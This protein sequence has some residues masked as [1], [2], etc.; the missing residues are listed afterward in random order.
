MFCSRLR[1]QIEA[2]KK[3][4]KII[5]QIWEQSF[6]FGS[7]KQLWKVFFLF[8]FVPPKPSSRKNVS[9]RSNDLF[10]S[11]QDPNSKRKRFTSERW[12]FLRD[13]IRCELQ[14][15]RGLSFRSSF[16]FRVLLICSSLHIYDFVELILSTFFW[17]H[18]AKR[19]FHSSLNSASITNRS[20]TIL[21][22]RIRSRRWALCLFIT[23]RFWLWNWKEDQIR[24][25]Q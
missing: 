15:K 5:D 1:S 6:V 3:R 8:G 2:E 18:I 13:W 24:W 11:I 10:Y 14:R 20:E 12:S 22:F 19:R 9:T 17:N 23:K 25:N 16:F 21:L 7:N 4:S